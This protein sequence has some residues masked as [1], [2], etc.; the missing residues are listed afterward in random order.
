MSFCDRK[1]LSIVYSRPPLNGCPRSGH[2][3]KICSRTP[4]N[5]SPQGPTADQPGICCRR[6][7]FDRVGILLRSP[8]FSRS[9]Q[10]QIELLRQPLNQ[11]IMVNGS[12][13]RVKCFT[14]LSVTKFWS[15]FTKTTRIYT[16]SL[17]YVATPT[18]TTVCHMER[19]DYVTLL[20]QANFRSWAAR[21]GF[22][23]VYIIHIES[24]TL[25]TDPISVS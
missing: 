13:C 5:C 20:S 24:T 9:T 25:T 19:S 6:E 16:L 21:S 1:G 23:T 8:S 3:L 10:Y 7:K 4:M 17:T 14:Q 18:F 11:S 2:P 22:F 12:Y 15:Y